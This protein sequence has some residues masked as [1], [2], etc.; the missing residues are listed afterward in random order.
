MQSFEPGPGADP[1]T[2]RRTARRRRASRLRILGVVV[3]AVV[4]AG[5]TLAGWALISHRTSHRAAPTGKAPAVPVATTRSQPATAASVALALPN[6]K[7]GPV[8]GYLLVADRNNNRL[9]ILSPAKKIV[10]RFPR[11]GDIKAGQS[12]HDPDDA[13]FTP[14]HLGIS[15]NEEFNYQMAL[16]SLRRHRITWSYGRAGV[17]GSAAGELSNPDDAYLLSRNRMMVADIRNCRVLIVDKAHR[18]VRS[19]G[20]PSR[21]YHHPPDSFSSPNGATPLADGGVL[22]T[23]IGGW[24]DRLDRNGRLVYTV[25]TPTSYPSDAQLLP[26]GNLLVAGFNTPG[27]VDI[28]SRTGAIRWTYSPAS[29][30][31]SLDR[32]SLAVRWPNGMIAVTDDWHHRIVVIDPKTKRIVWQYG[33]FGV[34]SSAPGYLSKPDGLDLLPAVAQRVTAQA[35]TR[36]VVP[37]GRTARSVSKAPQL[38][39]RVVGHLSTPAARVSV[40]ALP[41]GEI[42]ALGGLTAGGSSDQVLVGR[43][44]ALRSVGRLPVATHDAAAAVLGGRVFLF[45]GGQ[46]TSFDAIDRLDP[47][48]GAV[49]RVGTI[50]E[51]LSDL[52]AATV[53]AATYLVGGYTGATWATAI[54]RFVPGHVPT[55]VGRLPSGLRYAGVAPLGGRVY[56]AGGV[57]TAGTSSA[58]LVFDPARGTVRRIGSLPHPVAHGALVALGRA[59]YLIGGTDAAGSPLATLVRIDPRTGKTTG[60]GALPHALSDAGA[61]VT[62]GAIVVVGGK[63]TSPTADILELRPT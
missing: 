28:L 16:I 13:F 26:D 32:P 46:T 33:H 35:A 47:A 1:R 27:R 12:F 22:I 34:A 37:A 62:G 42:A 9:L 25:R 61:A 31:G 7:P 51:P 8:P 6:V 43:P 39:A 14:D 44:S 45:G 20:S 18:I 59:L 49:K 52:G 15:T 21:C 36:R 38:T 3:A 17:A 57:T 60:G 2:T 48:T 10:W 63:S 54:Q 29:G 30:P 55:V 58:I 41:H 40:V 5:A 4:V 56:V 53:G 24:I 50:G 11:P 19:Y 23:E